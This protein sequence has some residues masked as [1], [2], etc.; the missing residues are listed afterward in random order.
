M[1]SDSTT[2]DGTLT[3]VDT[4]LD[5]VVTTVH[6]ILVIYAITLRIVAKYVLI[7]SAFLVTAAFFL[8]VLGRVLEFLLGKVEEEEDEP[9]H[10]Q[11]YDPDLAEH[12]AFEDEEDSDGV[13]DDEVFYEVPQGFVQ[14]E[15]YDIPMF[16]R[17]G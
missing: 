16:L 8:Y 4:T 9:S 6:S 10:G 2:Y 7:G 5:V 13:V 1:F 11:K 12:Q 15:S 14:P 3:L 17:G